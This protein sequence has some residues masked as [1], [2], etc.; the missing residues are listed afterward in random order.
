MGSPAASARPGGAWRGRGP[1]KALAPAPRLADSLGLLAD[2]AAG[3]PPPARGGLLDTRAPGDP[4]PSELRYHGTG[5]W[6]G[7]QEGEFPAA[8]EVLSWL[9][10]P[11]G[12]QRQE[13]KSHLSPPPSSAALARH[14]CSC[15]PGLPDG[16]AGRG[17]GERRE[18]NDS[19][20]W[21]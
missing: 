8:R 6:P 10:G 9:Y 15:E 18:V 1:L 11:R 5:Q 20:A 7:D 17:V 13:F 2:G 4:A 21:V 3:D 12:P 19:T 16:E 14:L